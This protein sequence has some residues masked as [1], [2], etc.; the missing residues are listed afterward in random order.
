MSIFFS[1]HNSRDYTAVCY[2]KTFSASLFL[3]SIVECSNGSLTDFVFQLF[4]CIFHETGHLFMWLWNMPGRCSEKKMEF[5]EDKLLEAM[6][7][8]DD[9]A[10]RAIHD[11]ILEAQLELPDEIRKKAVLR[12][13]KPDWAPKQ[14]GRFHKLSC[15]NYAE[16]D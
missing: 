3:P 5:I 10:L 1:S 4:Q 14:V 7:E 9:S 11:I 16:A 2:R 6:L 12:N 8:T 13:I 15:A